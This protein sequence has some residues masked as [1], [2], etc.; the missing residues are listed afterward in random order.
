MTFDL[1][2]ILRY[3]TKS[4]SK[5]LKINN[6]YFISIGNVH[7]SKGTTIKKVKRNGKSTCNPC[8]W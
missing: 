8:F 5:R 4:K 3:D 6:I 1:A 2:N 7:L